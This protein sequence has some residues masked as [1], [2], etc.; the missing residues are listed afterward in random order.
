MGPTRSHFGDFACPSSISRV[1]QRRG[2]RVPN[3]NVA[4][5]FSV[6]DSRSILSIDVASIYDNAKT[7]AR[8]EDSPVFQSRRRRQASLSS[9]GGAAASC[10]KSTLQSPGALCLPFDAYQASTRWLCLLARHIM[11][12]CLY[13]VDSRNGGKSD[14]DPVL[15]DP[16]QLLL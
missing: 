11:R 8:D 15:R 12:T 2:K 1:A 14:F 16:L 13:G 9:C 7:V 4:F 5:F 3:R 10:E 6:Q